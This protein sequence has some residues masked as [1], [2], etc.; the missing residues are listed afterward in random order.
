MAINS[1]LAN[2]IFFASQGV[3]ATGKENTAGQAYSDEV[4]YAHAAIYNPFEVL[5]GNTQE[6]VVKIYETILGRT[7]PLVDDPTGVVYWKNAI[8]NGTLSKAAFIDEMT[9]TAIK[10]GGSDQLAANNANQAYVEDIYAS[11]LGRA[12]S[13]DQEG[14]NY[15][16]NA[17]NTG[18]VSR[19]QIVDEISKAAAANGDA[20]FKTANAAF[21]DNLYQSLLNRAADQEGKDYWVNELNSGVSKANLVVELITAANSG[22]GVD[23]D[24]LAAKTKALN[25]FSTNFTD[26]NVLPGTETYSNAR[27]L[28][29]AEI[30]GITAATADPVAEI[31]TFLNKD[32]KAQYEEGT[33]APVGTTIYATWNGALRAEWADA[34]NT[35]NAEVTFKADTEE[36]P[37]RRGVF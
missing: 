29:G 37:D 35:A 25:A 32:Y 30:K 9:A 18:A 4:S 6:F 13:D 33:P 27:N 28:A 7:N 20:G 10:N 3:P 15:W 12:A 2:Q 16:T 14:K 22:T 26:Y 8:D 11:V 1:T 5:G 19:S 36:E 23:K 34:T 17:L 24:N 31:T 21:I